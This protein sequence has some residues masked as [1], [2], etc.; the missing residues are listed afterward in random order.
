M[1]SRRATEYGVSR[2]TGG[3]GTAAAAAVASTIK[4]ASDGRSARPTL[5]AGERARQIG[6]A[7]VGERAVDRLDTALHLGELLGALDRRQ[8]VAGD[9]PRER[10]APPRE[11]LPRPFQLLDF[12][13]RHDAL[14]SRGGG[15]L[16]LGRAWRNR[17]RDDVPSATARPEI[18]RRGGHRHGSLEQAAP[19]TVR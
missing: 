16:A 2:G 10:A 15:L 1:R 9:H 3:T 5:F 6:L 7:G 18:T 12:L 11:T 14:Q 13:S 8:L 4:P 17:A 19:T